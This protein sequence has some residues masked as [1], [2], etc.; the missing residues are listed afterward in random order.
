M[1]EK[2]KC[3]KCESDNVKP[4][5]NSKGK[6]NWELKSPRVDHTLRVGMYLCQECGKKFRHTEK[7]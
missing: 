2:I 7:E 3:P 5:P 1:P 6:M 4:I